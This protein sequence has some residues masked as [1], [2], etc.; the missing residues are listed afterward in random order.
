MWLLIRPTP[1]TRPNVVQSLVTQNLL[2]SAH[3]RHYLCQANYQHHSSPTWC[4]PL[5]SQCLKLKAQQR[6]PILCPIR[7]MS[8]ASRLTYIRPILHP[9]HINLAHVGLLTIIPLLQTGPPTH[10]F[11]Q[12][13]PLYPIPMSALDSSPTS[14]TTTNTSPP[15]NKYKSLNKLI[16][17]PT[18]YLLPHALTASIN[19]TPTFEP[20]NYTQAIKHPHW[21]SAMQDEYDALLRNHTWSLVPA[22]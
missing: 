15:P 2:P 22:T 20:I 5:P 14:N 21:Q 7:K 18:K 4:H 12:Y 9:L 8:S 6:S 11:I 19:S 16:Y 3:F 1:Y 13:S 17:G 10:H